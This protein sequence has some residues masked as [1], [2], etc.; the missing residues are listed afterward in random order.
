MADIKPTVTP[1]GPSTVA[2]ATPDVELAKLRDALR[3][4]PGA[5]FEKAD[6][7]IKSLGIPSRAEIL[8]HIKS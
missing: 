7:F 8:A 3:S 5:V 1:K 6:N 4:G 2:R